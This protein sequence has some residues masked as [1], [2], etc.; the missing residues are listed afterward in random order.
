VKGKN[1]EFFDYFSEI[2]PEFLGRYKKNPDLFRFFQSRKEYFF[3]DVQDTSSGCEIR[4]FQQESVSPPGS[5]FQRNIPA[6][7]F[8]AIS[9]GTEP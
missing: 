7:I 6:G 5:F 3:I 9:G 1:P 8:P 2:F 4:A